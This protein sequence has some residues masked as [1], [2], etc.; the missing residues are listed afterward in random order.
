M[1]HRKASRDYVGNGITESVLAKAME[2]FGTVW[3]GENLCVAA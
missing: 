1:N 2:G 3:V